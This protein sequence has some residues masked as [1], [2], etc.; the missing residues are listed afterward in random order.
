MSKVTSFIKFTNPLILNVIRGFYLSN[1]RDLCHSNLS[2][3][4]SWQGI[5]NASQLEKV[6]QLANL[7]DNEI[8]EIEAEIEAVVSQN[9]IIAIANAKMVEESVE[10]LKSLQ[11]ELLSKYLAKNVRLPEPDYKR[12]YRY[13][14]V[15]PGVV[16]RYVEHAKK[17]VA[18]YHKKILRLEEKQVLSNE[19]VDYLIAK[20][21]K[22]GV[23]FTI[24][25]A[26]SYAND[27]AGNLEF[28]AIRLR[29]PDVDYSDNGWEAL[30]GHTFK[31]V[32]IYID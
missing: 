23:D 14:F 11:N 20:G 19:A 24:E 3:D 22:Y 7:T 30:P 9:K 2:S 15:E 17:L 12:W 27:V 5:T 10:T 8:L 26:L 21:K 13:D 29:N 25:N 31:N 28:D 4:M 16:R 6:S 18:N 32:Q 1:N